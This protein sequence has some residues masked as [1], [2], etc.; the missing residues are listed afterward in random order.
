SRELAMATSL[1][2]ALTGKF[3]PEK[4]RDSY[5]DEL[6]ALVQSKVEGGEAKPALDKA[7]APSVGSLMELMRKSVDALKSGDVSGEASGTAAGKA[8]ARPHISNV[9]KKDAP[10]GKSPKATAN[11]AA[12][13]DAKPA[14]KPHIRKVA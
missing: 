1:I 9:Q 8:A 14:R 11:K 6:L 10:S 12:E 7:P 4:Y 2:D 5:R 13:K 3:T